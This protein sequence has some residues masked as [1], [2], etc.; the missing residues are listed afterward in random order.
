MC[1]HLDLSGALSDPANHYVLQEWIRMEH[2]T[3]TGSKTGNSTAA[4]E[5]EQAIQRLGVRPHMGVMADRIQNRTTPL[6]PRPLSATLTPTLGRIPVDYT[7]YRGGTRTRS[8]D[9]IPAGERVTATGTINAARVH[10]DDDTPR[11]TFTLSSST[12]DSAIVSVGMDRYLD[13]FGFVVD[14]REVEV[15]GEVKRPFQGMPA[16]LAASGIAPRS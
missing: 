16:F 6:A 10:G 3:G 4:S 8:L 13:V 12:G 11:L 9:Q 2:R 14:G 1:H 7:D 15:T 5:Y